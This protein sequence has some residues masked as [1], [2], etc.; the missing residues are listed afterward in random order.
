MIKI[1][2]T[3]HTL[4]KT[5]LTS[6]EHQATNQDE[7]QKTF[8]STQLQLEAKKVIQL[9]DLALCRRMI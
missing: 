6:P 5:I 7:Y 4:S 2:N 9:L 1:I 3:E 8:H